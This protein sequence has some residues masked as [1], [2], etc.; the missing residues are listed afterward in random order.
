MIWNRIRALRR[1]RGLSQEQLGAMVGFSQ[2][3]MRKIG[4]GN[5]DSLSDLRLIAKALEVPIEGL[6]RDE[7][8]DEKQVSLV[9]DRRRT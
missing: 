4:N 2:S 1:Q 9:Y 6:V 8:G 7:R 5:C 3:K